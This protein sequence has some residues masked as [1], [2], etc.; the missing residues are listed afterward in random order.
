MLPDRLSTQ[1]T[2][3]NQDV[4][5]PSIIIEFVVATDGTVMSHDVYLSRVENRA[6]L[7]YG[8][9]GAWLDGRGQLPAAATSTVRYSP[10]TSSTR[11]PAGRRSRRGGRSAWRRSRASMRTLRARRHSCSTMRRPGSKREACLHVS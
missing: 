8:S 1:L 10:A 6:K 4:D 5:R 7:A 9:V 3:L 2:S 11:A